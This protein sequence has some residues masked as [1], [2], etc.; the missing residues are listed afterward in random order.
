MRNTDSKGLSTEEGNKTQIV[1]GLLQSK[2]IHLTTNPRAH[3]K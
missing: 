3:E 1:R 2:G